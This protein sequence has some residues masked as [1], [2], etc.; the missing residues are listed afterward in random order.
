MTENSLRLFLF[1]KI[2]DKIDNE[3]K[4][5]ST[6]YIKESNAPFPSFKKVGWASLKLDGGP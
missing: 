6:K 3:G 5:K 1:E 4:N 2:I